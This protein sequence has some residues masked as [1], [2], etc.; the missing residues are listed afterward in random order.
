[1]LIR[2]G[3]SCF[4]G[5]ARIFCNISQNDLLLLSHNI[6][7]AQCAGLFFLDHDCTIVHGKR[8]RP[9]DGAARGRSQSVRNQRITAL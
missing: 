1:M 2:L 5:R 4:T 6:K 7:E 8:W 9:G 3:Q